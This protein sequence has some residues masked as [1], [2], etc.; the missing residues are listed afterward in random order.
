MS[1]PDVPE[2]PEPYRRLPGYIIVIL[3]PP[4][5]NDERRRWSSQALAS[6]RRRR[7]ALPPG[8]PD[9]MAMLRKMRGYED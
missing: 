9:A 6:I 3:E 8:A 7:R 5:S 2:L 1:E 4:V